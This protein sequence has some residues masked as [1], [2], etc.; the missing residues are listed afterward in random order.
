MNMNI[1][2]KSFLSI[3]VVAVGLVTSFRWWAFSKPRKVKTFKFLSH[4]GELVVV[5]V[6]NIPKKKIAVNKQQVASWIGKDQKL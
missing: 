4:D 3:G 1:S 5:E 6:E 2:R